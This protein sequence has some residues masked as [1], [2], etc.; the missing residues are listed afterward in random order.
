MAYRVLADCLVVLHLAFV[1]FVLFGALLLPRRPH[2]AWLH[3]PAV[4]WGAL[5][6]VNAWICP[7]T[8]WEQQLRRIAGQSGYEG[9]FVEHY[10]LPVLYPAG[11]T[12][13][14]QL[15]LGAMVIIVN[16][17]LYAWAFGRWRKRAFGR[18]TNG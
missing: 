14:I 8:P 1:I 18:T 3:L 2:V 10:L 4:L 5:V 17:V 12:P 16:V 15:V 6:E 11:L 7:L 9:G 13:R